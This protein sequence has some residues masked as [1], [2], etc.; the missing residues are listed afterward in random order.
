MIDPGIQKNPTKE[1]IY[2][3]K[4]FFGDYLKTFPKKLKIILGKSPPTTISSRVR[5]ARASGIKKSIEN[6]H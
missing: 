3:I 5:I 1:V 2:Y 4:G 6:N